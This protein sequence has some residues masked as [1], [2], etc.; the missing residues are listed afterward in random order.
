MEQLIKQYNLELNNKLNKYQSLRD[1]DLFVL[2]NSIR[3]S[4]VGQ[5]RGHTSEDKWR[6]FDEVKKCGFTN[7]IVASLTDDVHVDD[8]FL[9]ELVINAEDTTGLYVFSEITRSELFVVTL[10]PLNF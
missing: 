10:I 5:L 2:D 8:D 4:T 7:A 1:L 6:I 3:G 9:E